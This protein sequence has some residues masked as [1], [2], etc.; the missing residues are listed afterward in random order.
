MPSMLNVPA[1][2]NSD[3]DADHQADVAGAGGEERLERGGRLFAPSS[4]QWPISA[5]EQRPTTSQP[6]SIC[7]VFSATTSS[8]IDA[9][10]RR[11]ASRSSACSARRRACTRSSRR[12]RAARS[13]VTTNSIITARPSTVVPTVKSTPPFC[14]H[15]SVCTTGA[16]TGAAS[17][18]RLREDAPAERA[19][20]PRCGR[21]RRRRGRSTATAATID[22]TNDAP[23]ASDADLGALASGGASRR[24]GSATNETAGIAGM[25][26]AWSSIGAVSPSAGRR[27]RDRHC[28]GCG[29]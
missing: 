9:V 6:T 18:R 26:Q 10:N 17:C 1:A 13:S 3:D 14:H 12:A 11:Q 15:V 27:R 7:S 28:A 23:T 4:H 5:N 19:R 2:K 20:G 16:T 22:S 24:T 8:S 25:I 29:R 21:W